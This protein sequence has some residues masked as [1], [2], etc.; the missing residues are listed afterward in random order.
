[1]VGFLLLRR[2]DE[3]HV[4][5]E[6][7]ISKFSSKSFLVGRVKVVLKAKFI[8]LRPIFRTEVEV[9]IVV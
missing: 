3:L 7:L 1:L 8:L 6:S 4:S 5:F 9:V 2:I